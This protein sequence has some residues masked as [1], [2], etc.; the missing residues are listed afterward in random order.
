M[1]AAMILRNNLA[2]SVF[3][4][5]QSRES[6]ARI[7]PGARRTLLDREGAEAPQLDAIAARHRGDDLAQDG[8]DDLLDVALI[9]VGI[10]RRNTLHKFG[11]D[12][13]ES[14]TAP[15]TA[16]WTVPGSTM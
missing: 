9:E 12:H 13:C 16:F 3:P 4:P 15:C 11:L 6:G 7:A 10:L 14:W 8:V 1:I 2:A 5:A